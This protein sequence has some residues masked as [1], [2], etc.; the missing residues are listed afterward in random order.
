MP[1]EYSML[2]PVSREAIMAVAKQILL[3]E[4]NVQDVDITRQILQEDGIE[5]QF[6]ELVIRINELTHHQSDRLTNMKEQVKKWHRT[7]AEEALSALSK[8]QRE[9]GVTTLRERFSSPEPNALDTKMVVI[10]NEALRMADPSDDSTTR[11]KLIPSSALGI[12]ED[13]ES[14]TEI[15]Y[16]YETGNPERV[17]VAMTVYE[18]V[19]HCAQTMNASEPEKAWTMRRLAEFIVNEELDETA[20]PRSKLERFA[21]S[22]GAKHAQWVTILREIL[23][24]L[25][26]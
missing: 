7:L 11:V 17:P 3:E 1:Y 9:S 8:E 14:Y 4:A 19:E 5:R 13:L 12:L 20:D 21:H 23:Q 25:K 2:P 18:I 15:G 10:L 26:T 22:S 16:A 6:P 24:E